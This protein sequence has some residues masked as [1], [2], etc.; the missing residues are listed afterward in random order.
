VS[1]E[2]LLVGEMAPEL[3]TYFCAECNGTVHVE[4]VL[5]TETGRGIIRGHRRR[6]DQW[7]VDADGEERNV[8]TREYITCGPIEVVI[9]PAEPLLQRVLR[10][11]H[12]THHD[13]MGHR[14]IGCPLCPQ[15]TVLSGT[16]T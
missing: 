4:H 11:T 9:T 10:Q 14:V 13:L 16:R 15:L 5:T 2:K 8:G 3:T 12:W 1:E 7:V 6:D